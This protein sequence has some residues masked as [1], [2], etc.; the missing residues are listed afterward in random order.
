MKRHNYGPRLGKLVHQPPK[1]VTLAYD[2]RWTRTI[3]RYKYLSEDYKFDVS[4]ISQ[5]PM[6]F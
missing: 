1:D 5:R 2:I 4:D 6:L 3:P